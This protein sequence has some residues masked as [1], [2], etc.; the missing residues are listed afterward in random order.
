M[1]LL[2]TMS[3]VR[4]YVKHRSLLFPTIGDDLRMLLTTVGVFTLVI[5]VVNQKFP[6]KHNRINGTKKEYRQN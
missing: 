3:L 1:A 4:D 6:A 5:L 2:R